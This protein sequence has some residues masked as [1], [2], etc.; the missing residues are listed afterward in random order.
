MHLFIHLSVTWSSFSPLHT[1]SSPCLWDRKSSIGD[2]YSDLQLLITKETQKFWLCTS[3]VIL[4][5]L[6]KLSRAGYHFC[7]KIL[8]L[9]IWFLIGEILY[10]L[11]TQFP[12]NKGEHS[13][14]TQQILIWVFYF[15]LRTKYQH[16]KSLYL[17]CPFIS[18]CP[19]RIYSPRQQSLSFLIS[20]Y[21]PY[22][23]Y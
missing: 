23:S 22:Y 6:F 7:N 18:K 14:E 10:I 2:E 15:A 11:P 8:I 3:C 1:L 16:A 13:G 12:L 9:F 4:S 21:Q 17:R 5:K 20:V 19:K